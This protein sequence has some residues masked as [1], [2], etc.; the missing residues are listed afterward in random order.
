MIFYFSGTGN[1]KWV[2][3]QLANHFSDAL[4]QIGEYERIAA[5]LAP[6]FELKSDEKIGFVFPIH[7]WG[8]PPIVVDFIADMQWSGYNNQLIY[9]VMTCGGECG[10]TKHQFIKVMEAKGLGCQHIYSVIMPNSYICMKGFDIDPKNVQ[11]QKKQQ[12][13]IDLPK[14]ISAIEKDQPIDFYQKGKRFSKIKSTLI[15]KIFAKYSL[16]D[17]A[18]SSNEECTS[19]GKCVKVCP[20]GNIELFDGKPVWKGNCT[21]CLACIHHCPTTAIEYGKSTKNKGRYVFK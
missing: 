19:C 2:A 18:F 11:E 13:N 3:T 1:S 14:I 17:Q 12:V 16:T 20:V 6:Q 5:P 21:Q 9:C 8:M 10:L 7:S 15:Y 4:Y